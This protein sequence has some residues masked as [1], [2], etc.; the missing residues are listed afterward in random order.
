MLSMNHCKKISCG[1]GPSAVV[2]SFPGRTSMSDPYSG[3]DVQASLATAFL[4][5]EPGSMSGLFQ[6]IIAN[7]AH[8]PQSR[9][10][11][12]NPHISLLPSFSLIF[13]FTLIEKYL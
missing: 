5:L 7:Y 10:D 9:T 8:E 6:S 3:F 12:F 11:R 1:T 4:E 2:G 13:I